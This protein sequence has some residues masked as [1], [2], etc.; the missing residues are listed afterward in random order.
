[1]EEWGEKKTADYV[2]LTTQLMRETVEYAKAKGSLIPMEKVDHLAIYPGRTIAILMDGTEIEIT[3]KEVK[4]RI[5]K[6]E[7]LS[8]QLT[9]AT[10]ASALS[11]KKA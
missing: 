6:A 11:P 2:P 10:P 9:Q 8:G 4:E 5:Q 1:M 7:K 3:P